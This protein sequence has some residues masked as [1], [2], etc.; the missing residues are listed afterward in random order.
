[1]TLLIRINIRWTGH[2]EFTS[3]SWEIVPPLLVKKSSTTNPNCNPK[4]EAYLRF[5][6]NYNGIYY[7]NGIE[8]YIHSSHSLYT[9]L[10]TL[11][12]HDS[13]II[14]LLFTLIIVILEISDNI[15]IYIVEPPFGLR[16]LL[17]F[18]C[19]R[20]GYWCTAGAR[21]RK[22]GARVGLGREK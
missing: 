6:T 7:Y 9:N 2:G 3:T 16:L 13:H 15:Y 14:I 21:K 22:I 11:D 20:G 10:Y 1:M 5:I 19:R 8:L 12:I 17:P 4:Y 18:W